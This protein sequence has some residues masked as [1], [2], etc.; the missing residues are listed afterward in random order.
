MQHNQITFVF[1]ISVFVQF[2]S[3]N[4]N[5]VSRAVT[6]HI[7]KMNAEGVR[8]VGQYSVYRLFAYEHGET[9]SQR[10]VAMLGKFMDSAI[11][12]RIDRMDAAVM[13]QVMAYAIPRFYEKESA[14]FLEDFRKRAKERTE[15]LRRMAREEQLRAEREPLRKLR[16]LYHV[17]SREPLSVKKLHSAPQPHFLYQELQ[18]DPFRFPA[19]IIKLIAAYSDRKNETFIPLFDPCDSS[20]VCNYGDRAYASF[21]VIDAM[22]DHFP[23]RKTCVLYS[24]DHGS[25]HVFKR[26]DYDYVVNM[27]RAWSNSS[28]QQGFLYCSADSSSVHT[29]LPHISGHMAALFSYFSRLKLI[30]LPRDSEIVRIGQDNSKVGLGNQ[31]TFVDLMKMWHN[32]VYCLSN[33]RKTLPTKRFTTAFHAWGGYL[34]DIVDR[35]KEHRSIIKVI[36]AANGRL[37]PVFY[38]D[39]FTSLKEQVAHAQKAHAEG[40]MSR[41]TINVYKRLPLFSFIV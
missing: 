6:D 15:E 24:E 39:D 34:D 18:R 3:H 38:R 21:Y 29:S 33:K 14:E 40:P 31:V 26:D 27:L 1:C 4:M 36:I 12:E 28:P 32:A 8:L 19:D 16:E 11:K 2:Y 17:P 5:L 10:N 9:E 25:S 41:G 30:A 22:P 35:Y 23:C 7:D 13:M 20:Y 37:V